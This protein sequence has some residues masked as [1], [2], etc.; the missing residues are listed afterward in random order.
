MTIKT[1]VH[2]NFRG[3][4]RQALTFYQSVFS[5]EITLVT[6]HDAHAAAEPSQADQILWGQVISVDGFQIM[7][8]DV[9]PS[10]AWSAGEIPFYVSVRGDDA[11]TLTR[12]WAALSAD[13]AV[14]EPLG[15]AGFSPLYG[16]VKD[17]FGVTWV[18]DLQTA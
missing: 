13:G 18:L 12:Y 14:I 7:A 16:M 17:A 4:A 1:V 5:G 15:A 2:L 9:P 8:Y 10:K 6:Y 3:N 11:E